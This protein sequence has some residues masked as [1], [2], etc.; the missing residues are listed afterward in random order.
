MPPRQRYRFGPLLDAWPDM[1]R[2]GTCLK[3]GWDGCCNSGM[4]IQYIYCFAVWLHLHNDKVSWL[5]WLDSNQRVT[6]SKS[7]ALAAW[8]HP[9]I[10]SPRSGFEPSNRTVT[11]AFTRPRYLPFLAYSPG[12]CFGRGEIGRG[13]W[14][15]TNVIRVR[16]GCPAVGRCPFIDGHRSA[17]AMAAPYSM[18]RAVGGE[19]C[20]DSP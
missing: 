8:L 1:W 5:G 15:R 13:N 9:N 11:C 7:V 14:I 18:V 10:W 19:T 2:A 12:A 4:H 17:T 6:E 20:M 3:N 16:A